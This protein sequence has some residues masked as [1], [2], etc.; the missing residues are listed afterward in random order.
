M[1]RISPALPLF[2][3]FMLLSA[4][5]TAV[6]Y[7]I[8]Y[9]V[10][11]LIASLLGPLDRYLWIPPVGTILV[12]LI[13]LITAIRNRTPDITSLEWDSGT[14][15]DS[16]SR[17]YLPGKGGRLWNVNP[18]GP[19]SIGSIGAIGGAFL[20]YGQ[21]LAVTAFVAAAE[22]WRKNSQQ[23]ADGKTPE[24]PQPPN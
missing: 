10:I 6:V 4:F 8:V 11:Y 3:I 17:H 21:S 22:E 16:P 24:A 18:C 12:F 20:S 15:E 2:A 7:A 23:S 9:V 1:K 13:G 19:R 14:I 5:V